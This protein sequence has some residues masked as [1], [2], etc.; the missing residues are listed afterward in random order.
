MTTVVM[1]H[2]SPSW[3]SAVLLTLS[4]FALGQA[5]Q[6]NNGFFHG[7]GIL[8]LTASA[9]LIG[10]ACVA[11]RRSTPVFPLRALHLVLLGAILFQL[12]QL[13]ADPPLLYS[14]LRH[15]RDDPTLAVSLSVIGAMA[16][17]LTAGGV[18]IQRAAFAIILIA[19]VV[20][21]VRVIRL[22]PEPR[23]D[24][25]TVQE[26]AIDAIA[27]GKSPYGITFK[28]IYG[29][30]TRFYGDGMASK[31][32]VRFGFPYPP[33]SL[34]FVAP[35][36]WLLGDYRYAA[37]AAIAIAGL[38]LASLGWSRHAMLAATL[39]LT[40]PRVLFEIEQGWTEPFILVM[41]AWL[42]AALRRDPA[43]AAVVAGL[44]MAVKQYFAVVL[45]LFP[46]MPAAPGG[47]GR[48]LAVAVGV[49]AAMTL[50]FL[51]WDVDGFMK[52]V[53][54]LQLRE[55]FR[56][57]SLSYL[58][59]LARRGMQPPGVAITLLALAAATVF[60]SRTLPRSPAG[61]AAGMAL[62]SLAV[63]AFGKKAFCNYYF[64]VI[65]VMMT[66]VAAADAEPSND[67]T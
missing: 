16:I 25:V 5:L 56:L 61:F 7:R 34:A 21:G 9:A 44:G 8:W 29:S 12:A 48:R 32:E 23:I 38:L 28:N 14:P 53:V 47:A 65:G 15:G 39:L 33:L 35:A 13:L 24:V 30:E 1:R 36:H 19:H 3:I 52:S 46:L 2:A 50:P 43:R 60:A 42:V 22:V 10:A 37:V 31:D 59:W 58:A 54:T 40:T 6:V 11:A 49:A 26:A 57:D 64:F 62:V 4:A 45:L 20:A 18:R 55:P 67:I 66:A 41:F 27:A 17:A 63:F 51:I